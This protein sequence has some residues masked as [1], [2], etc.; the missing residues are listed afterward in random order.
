MRGYMRG[1]IGFVA[2]VALLA[3][4]AAAMAQERPYPP[5]DRGGQAECPPRAQAGSDGRCVAR[6]FAPNTEVE[7]V[8]L[9]D[10]FERRFTVRANAGGVAVAEFAIPCPTPVGSTIDITFTGEA[11]EG[12]TLTAR[13][14]TTVQGA[15]PACAVPRTGADISNGL[16]A[17]AAVILLGALLLGLERRRRTGKAERVS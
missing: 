7:V 5:P 2:V 9:G 3:L 17:A 15:A 4:P 6:G 1:L 13:G 12:G 10:G 14:Q 8:V 11:A 16:A